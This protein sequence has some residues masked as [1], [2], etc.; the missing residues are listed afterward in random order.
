[1]LRIIH[2]ILVFSILT[3]QSAWAINTSNI[4]DSETQH[5]YTQIDDQHDTAADSCSHFCHASAHLVGICS[6]VS[7][8]MMIAHDRYTAKL[9]NFTLSINYQPP[10]PPPTV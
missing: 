9:I 4:S 6:N 1:M 8:D 10:T 5:V 3:A 2:L 7:I